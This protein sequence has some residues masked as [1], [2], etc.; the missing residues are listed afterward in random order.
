MART[1][2]ATPLR[3]ETSSEY[4]SIHDRTPQKQARS[5]N[6]DAN[7]QAV[8]SKAPAKPDNTIIQLVIA[9]AGIYGSL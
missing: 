2:Q 5:P 9:V 3:R 7:G 8:L 1:K 4:F 6:G